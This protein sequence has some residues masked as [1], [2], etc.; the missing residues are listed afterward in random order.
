APALA[1]ALR[2]SGESATQMNFRQR[3]Y[4]FRQDLGQF[5]GR[6]LRPTAVL[7]GALLSL[8]VFS[9]ATTIVLQGRREG[10]N[11][12]AAVRLYRDAFPDRES[13][14]QN[15]V[16]ALGSE[17]RAAQK[18]ADFLGLYAG[19]RSALELLAQLSRSIPVDLEVRISE[20]NIDRNT[21]RL[22]VDA[23]GYEAADRL[24]SVLSATDP[25]QGARV[26]GSVKT[27]RRTGGVSFDVSIPLQLGG[28]EA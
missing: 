26:A 11:Q 1:L 15:P 12:S 16:G 8:L 17:L 2:F 19:N 10:R 22:D 3:E 23:Q 21:I 4:S 13:V 24:T 7:A 6:E 27:D 5:F 20:I 14:P 18:R 9:A 25:F 28:D